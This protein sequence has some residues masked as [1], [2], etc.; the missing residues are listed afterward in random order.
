VSAPRLHR[1]LG[2]ALAGAT[3]VALALRIAGLGAQ[4]LLWD[5][6]LAGV[7]ARNFVELGWPGPMMWHHP[8]LRDLL[9]HVST[10][11]LGSGAWGLKAWSVLLGTLAVPATGYLVWIVSASRP[12]AVLSAA[13]VATDPLHVDFSRQAVNDVYLS[14][15]PVAA[16]IGLLLYAERRRPWQLV[17]AGLFLALGVASKWS[18]VFPVGAA[19]ALT[20][21]AGIATAGSRRARSAELALAV[22]ALVLLPAAAYVL[23]FWPWFG[24][25]HDLVEFVRFQRAMGLEAATHTGMAGTMLAG[26]PSNQVGAWRWF[27]QPVWWVDAVLPVSGRSGIPEGVLFLTGIGNPVTWLATFPATAWAAWRWFRARDRAAGVL[28]ALWLAAYLPF[29][30]VPRPI[31]TNSAVVVVPFWAALVGLAGARLWERARYLFAAWAAVAGL[32]ALLLW[33]PA[34]GLS[35]GPSDA[36]VR[37]IVSPLALDPAYHPATSIYGADADP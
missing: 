6:E 33:V 25:G 2:I 32:L 3:L 5:D 26:Y 27:L 30:L 16:I 12:A 18:A 31:F 7:T 35:F 9:I 37:A 28:L 23:T 21:P 34:T 20:V 13:I 17:A 36:L 14:F 24:R 29:A 8:R 10:G 11:V 4:P 19:V 22:G 15:F 1:R